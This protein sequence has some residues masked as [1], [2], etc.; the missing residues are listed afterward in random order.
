MLTEDEKRPFIDE[1]KRLRAQHM[2]EHPDYKYRPRRKPKTLRKDGYPYS[3]PYPSVSMDAL[4]AGRISTL[5]FP[6]IHPSRD[7]IHGVVFFCL[8]KGM[9]NPMTQM[10][11]Y[12]PAAAAYSSLSAA[13]MAAAAAA[14]AVQQTAIAGLANSSPQQ[15]GGGGGG[16]SSLDAARYSVEAEKYR[17]YHHNA[18]YGSAEHMTAAAK[19]LESSSGNK[20]DGGSS[21]KSFEAKT[22]NNSGG[23]QAAGKNSSYAE[24]SASSDGNNSSSTAAASKAY[25]ESAKLYMDSKNYAAE[26]QRAY[27][28]AAAKSVMYSDVGKEVNADASGGHHPDLKS[29]RADGS[30]PPGFNPA[31]LVN[32][33]HS[34][35]AAAVAAAGSN[36]AG[37][38]PHQA[39]A[40]SGIVPLTALSQ[41]PPPAGSYPSSGEYRRPLPVLF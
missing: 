18:L 38:S 25:L 7:L 41:Y 16:G 8:N 30:S 11:S 10:N 5:F 27:M 29:E 3:L 33:Y 15:L 6:S 17:G 35:A 12:Y 31:S 1:A 20:S 23:Y 40:L 22:D 39:P 34:Q 21:Q 13:S 24:S 2:K 37:L 4:R 19:Y 26:V 28:D 14:A 9:T 36:P 32:Y